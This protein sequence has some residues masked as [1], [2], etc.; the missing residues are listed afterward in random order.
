MRKLFDAAARYV[1]E[2]DMFL[3]STS[4]LCSIFGCILIAS[5]ARIY[6]GRH[7]QIQI[8]ATILGIIL[9]VI[10]SLFD[11]DLIADKYKLLFVVGALFILTLVKWG[12]SGDTVNKAWLRFGG[13][14]IQPAEVV[15]I[16]FIIIIAHM[17]A[18]KRDRRALNAPSSILSML[19]VFA[20]YFVLIVEVSAD[21]GSASVYLFILLIMFF[22][23]GVSMKWFAIAGAAIAA[24]LPLMWKFV[25][26]DY[27]KL[28]VQVIFDKELAATEGLKTLWQANQSVRAISSGGFLGQGL[29]RGR[30]TQT[31]LIPQQHTDFIFSAAGEEL[32]F[33]GCIAIV[34][35]LCALIGRCIYVGVKSNNTLGFLVCS[36]VA[37]T[38]I[39]QTLENIGMCL[40]ITPVIGLTLPFFSYGGSSVV[41]TYIMMG[42]VCG[43]KMRPRPSRY[44]NM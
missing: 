28:R 26:D 9:F 3:L 37:A 41:T 44:R 25:L 13:I 16:I 19:F 8:L 21:L 36:G 42:L 2:A 12:E 17:I 35:L 40:G 5:A 7:L 29:F 6:N 31:D 33:V 15:K 18:D 27:Q 39:F 10:T 4:L 43:V 22:L 34:A 23:G 20:V 24:A 30:M 1:R 11:I 14:G 32:G 38:L